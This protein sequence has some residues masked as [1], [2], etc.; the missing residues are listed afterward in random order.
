[1]KMRIKQEWISDAVL[2]AKVFVLVAIPTALLVVHVWNQFRITQVG[3]EIAAVTT[4]HRNLLEENKKLTVEARIQ[5][6]SDRV[7]EVA[8]QQFGLAETRPEQVITVE[9]KRFEEK[10]QVSRELAVVH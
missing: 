6:R 5:G 1:M 2:V 4:E 3:Y 10:N 8:R 9:L 7:A